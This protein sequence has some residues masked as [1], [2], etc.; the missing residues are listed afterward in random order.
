MVWGLTDKLKRNW[1]RR[2]KARI[3]KKDHKAKGTHK[4][5]RFFKEC[6]EKM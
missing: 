1:K 5:A 4:L 6:K 3:K 2:E